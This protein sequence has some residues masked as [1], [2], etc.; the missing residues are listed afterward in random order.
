MLNFEK[1]GCEQLKEIAI[2]Q[3]KIF[4]N[5]LN[6]LD[7][8]VLLINKDLTVEFL[9]EKAKEFFEIKSEGEIPLKYFFKDFELEQKKEGIQ[10]ALNLKKVLDIDNLTVIKG[11]EIWVKNLFIPIEDIESENYKVLLFIKD[12]TFKKY[13]EDQ[14]IK[15]N[16]RFAKIFQNNPAVVLISRVEDGKII[17]INSSVEKVFGYT[18]N[19]I[20]G[21]S[22]LILYADPRE[23]AL[24]IDKIL[25]K[26]PITNFEIK[27]RR[28]DGTIGWASI[29]ADFIE[30][31]EENC[32]IAIINDITEKKFSS[33]L[34]ETLYK[35]SNII[36][37]SKNLDD[38]F[39]KL[40]QEIKNIIFSENFYIAIHNKESNIISFPYFVDQKDNH[41]PSK[42]FGNGLTEY[43][44]KTK[45]TKLL[46][47]Q[48]II[49]LSRK[50]EVEIVGTLSEYW[51][52]VP[53][54]GDNFSG[55]LV[56]QSYDEN[57]KYSEKDKEFLSFVGQQI[58]RLIDRKILEEKMSNQLKKYYSILESL[59]N[60]F[61][62]VDNNFKIFFYN[63]R[64]LNYMA[65][66]KNIGT[67]IKITDIIPDFYTSEI[68]FLL[69]DETFTR[70]TFSFEFNGSKSLEIAKIEDG[71]IFILL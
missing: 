41:A 5:F 6:L 64:F 58:S 33:L 29:S 14:N 8:V 71:F 69:K 22:T 26:G 1:Y 54:L 23:R 59:P 47:R 20:L 70:K 30:I 44:L 24:F 35:I 36:Y 3:E 17:E 56:V 21:Q 11:K 16:E 19:E 40:H 49:N 51:L 42:R 52:G 12:I 31:D 55:V 61:F 53:L 32:I 43:V 2:K 60:P 25:T 63:D 68:H 4:F 13:V 57:L 18:Q 7:D 34:N 48:D 15:V 45:E 67:E 37:S 28:K 39:T 46:T 62:A 10:K 65:K 27:F 50:G 38:L 9:N 66:H